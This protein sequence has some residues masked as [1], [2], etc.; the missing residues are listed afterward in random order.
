MQ[1]PVVSGLHSLTASLLNS[2]H[3]HSDVVVLDILIT[4]LLSLFSFAFQK[5]FSERQYGENW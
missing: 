1:L 4:H 5:Y 3:F 2:Y